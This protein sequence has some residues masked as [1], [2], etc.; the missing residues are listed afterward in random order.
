MKIKELREEKGLSQK[1]LADN[2]GTSQRNIGRW[3]NEENEPTMSQ[4]IKLAEYFDCTIDYLVGKDDDETI[5][6]MTSTLSLKEQKLL[7]S[8]ALLDN[9]EKDKILS[10]IEFYANRNTKLN[11]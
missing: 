6:P 7:K 5:S 9:E 4:L 3:E 10:D 11:K 1:K 8:F 2:I